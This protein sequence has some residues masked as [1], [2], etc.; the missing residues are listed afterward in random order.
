[1]A[2]L[3]PLMLW[4]SLA[5]VVPLLVHLFG[6]RR[7]ATVP[8]P[9][10]RFLRVG[11]ARQRSMS[12]LRQWLLLALRMLLVLAATTALAR[13]MAPVAWL[14][15][16]F[17]AEGELC[18]I[19]DASS[20]MSAR[21]GEGTPMQRA[22]EAANWLLARVPASV[23]TR[24]FAATGELRETA[25]GGLAAT[26]HRGAVLA[27]LSASPEAGLRRSLT[28]LAII[29]D[30]QT[31]SFTGRLGWEPGVAPLVLDVGAP[32]SN[33]A[34]TAA[35]S[36]TPCPLASR[37][38]AWQIAARGWGGAQPAAV[39]IAC[40]ADGRPLPGCSARIAGSAVGAPWRYTPAGGGD[41]PLRF[42]L[43]PDACA[44]DNTLWAVDRVRERLRV[45]L[46]AASSD[47]RYVSWA[48]AP[49]PWS[50]GPVR[51]TSLRWS[52]LAA[53]LP[54]TDLLILADLP[55]VLPAA[56]DRAARGDLPVILFAGPGAD[57][58]EDL[59]VALFGSAITLGPPRRRP[60]DSPL[61]I[62][63]L[64]TQYPALAPFAS[65][66]AGDLGAFSFR[67]TRP[68]QTR[69][70][71]IARFG[72]GTPAI[73]AGTR[74]DRRALLVNATLDTGWTDAPL[75]PAF[76][77]WVHSMCYDG[78]GPREPTW[79][80]G[81]VGETLR[82]RVPRDAGAANVTAPDGA[83]TAVEPRDGW[84]SFTPALPGLYT[85]T[86]RTPGG[87][88]S[89]RFA[90]NVSP[91]ES[92]PARLSAAELRRRLR[93]P[94]TVIAGQA[95]RERLVST[96]LRGRADLSWPCA[97]LVVLLL[98]AETLLSGRPRPGR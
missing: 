87:P 80:D 9:T 76:V 30:L 92:D 10:L 40:E 14:A 59:S 57:L 91:A 29:S 22:R 49:D 64:D 41:I 79:P 3:N 18:I 32:W 2:F 7:L 20:S 53:T 33:T 44:L 89:A 26:A 11:V 37:P 58:P 25:A 93:H 62:A 31:S 13:P 42:S 23:H 86:W 98:V 19:V 17:P 47:P 36:V 69:A 78:V 16:W 85:A 71:V 68:L 73:V 67:T 24:L 45:T 39:P 21:A 5:A 88:V 66:L 63:W 90:A 75:Q 95:D 48:L 52:A 74:P 27:A 61:H 94:S 46:I 55:P 70:R 15:R 43:P 35:R 8:F 96:W 51:P 54:A 65:P 56:V 72:D 34:L 97:V 50:P 83:R 81:W 4:G 38:S 60:T 12:R 84:W 82:T 6:R 28:R 1:M 77:P